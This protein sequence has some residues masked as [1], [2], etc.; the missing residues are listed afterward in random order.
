MAF[1]KKPL[2]FCKL[3]CVSAITL[4]FSNVL[5]TSESPLILKMKP[6]D[7]E[8]ILSWKAGNSSRTSACY[9]V[10]YTM[11]GNV[12]CN[13][14]TMGTELNSAA[15]GQEQVNSYNSRSQESQDSD[16]RVVGPG[17][18]ATCPAFSET[19]AQRAE[20][21]YY[22][23]KSDLKT[24][25]ECTNITRL[26]CNLTNEFA[27]F[28]Q[29]DA[30]IIVQHDTSNGTNYS[31][32]LRFSPYTQRCL[33]PP[34][35]NISVCQNCVNVTVKLPPL[36]LKIYQKLDYRITVKTAD[37]KENRIDNTTQQDSFF[38][39]LE[40]LHPNKNYCIAVQVSNSFKSQCT[41]TIPKCIM[42]DSNNGQVYTIL[43]ILALLLLFVGLIL[44]FL[45]MT[46]FIYFK[47]RISPN[48]LNI[49]PN[50]ACSVFG[51]DLEEI[52][53]VQVQ[54]SNTVQQHSEDENSES[55]DESNFDTKCGIFNKITP[56]SDV[57]ITQKLKT[58][59]VISD[60]AK[61][62]HTPGF[63]AAATTEP[64][65][66]PHFGKKPK[67]VTYRSCCS[68]DVGGALMWGAGSADG[69]SALG[70]EELCFSPS[71]T[72]ERGITLVCYC[73]GP[74]AS[75]V[76]GPRVTWSSRKS[77]QGQCCRKSAV[78]FGGEAKPGRRLAMV[79]ENGPEKLVVSNLRL[80]LLVNTC[81]YTR[82]SKYTI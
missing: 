7:F 80:R 56:F 45:C 9:T 11:K 37:F 54:E 41:S 62:N 22:L 46:G 1:S 32:I 21:N 77:K 69:K 29:G 19:D 26:F 64:L 18:L 60:G 79:A 55:D 72:T 38:T 61:K 52:C 43:S 58:E 63:A 36:L 14:L 50:M 27:D 68:R 71:V 70:A 49:K 66:R 28:C 16:H 3:V 40:D 4:T 31:D 78:S 2:N 30:F 74:A 25:Q 10:M 23:R 39:I 8:Y 75:V 76:Q 20:M 13:F 73:D 17:K 51:S 12:G 15:K 42:L 24:V 65:L 48:V 67:G 59:S 34:R 82:A 47:R 81:N 44:V 5:E 57:A 35:F 6:E 33:K 53:D